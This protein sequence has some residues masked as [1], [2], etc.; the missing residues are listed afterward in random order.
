MAYLRPGVYVEETL[1][2][3]P[4]I[5]GS[6]A[7]SIATFIGY[8][9]KGPTTPTLVGSWNEYVNFYGS[10][11]TDTARNKVATAVYLFFANGGGQCYVQRVTGTSA[12]ATATRTLNDT[13]AP[14]PAATLAVSANNPGAWGN[15]IAIGVTA[16]SISTTYFTLSVY[17]GGGT[18][19]YIVERFTD[20][21]MKTSDPRYAVNVI[22]GSSSYITV[23]DSS[24]SDTFEATD[25]P[26]I[27]TV[28]TPLSLSSGADGT[29]PTEAQIVAAASLLDVVTIPVLLNAPGVTGATDVNSLISYASGRGDAFVVIDGSN[30]TVSDQITLANS[31]TS[32]SYAA[33]YYPN[34]VIP[35]PTS[36]GVGATIL[37]NNGGAVIGK[38]VATDASRGVFKS[39]AGLDSRIAGAVSVTNLTNANLD[40]LN[41]NGAAVNAIRY[42]P[43][44]GIVI[45]GA[46]TLKP[47]YSDRYISVRRSLIYLRK[48][49]S[50]LTEFAI[51]EPND[52]RLHTR[53]EDTVSN[54]LT[55]FWQQGGLA[56]AT[57]AD[58]F[59]VK[60]DDG[61]NTPSTIAN[62]SVIIE[63]GVALQR[64]A[65]FVIIRIS[66]Y[67][68]G[69]VV[70]VS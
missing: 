60:C 32:S 19:G 39:P 40:T 47:G 59:F 15:N 16:S 49:L 54:F 5:A 12:V 37:A 33:V 9:D 44:S 66:Q 6:E 10:W 2:P 63:V 48:S 46:R 30:G 55:K 42:V 41:S 7:G 53:L 3:I 61:N 35:S 28:G 57:P 36:T 50:D 65:E 4:P 18:D 45:M 22:N 70:T 23:V 58:A 14:T 24:F 17:Y 20:V 21:T 13:S 26:A 56:G 25:N 69:A 43:G 51:F 52:F 1:S 64:P 38:I 27:T 8:T 11:S 31:Y 68:S 29:L 67:D 34:L 62:G